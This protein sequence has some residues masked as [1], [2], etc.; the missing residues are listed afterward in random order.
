VVFAS[1]DAYGVLLPQP[2]VK[3]YDAV[4]FR[5]DE[6]GL[7]GRLWQVATVTDTNHITGDGFDIKWRD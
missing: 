3:V 2:L 5:V 7:F 4:L 6:S 1:S